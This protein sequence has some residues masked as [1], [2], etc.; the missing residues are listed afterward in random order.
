MIGLFITLSIITTTCFI[1]AFVT[2]TIDLI[3]EI[4]NFFRN[5]QGKG[6][7]Q[8]KYNNVNLWLIAT[9]CLLICTMGLLF[10]Y[11]L[12]GYCNLPNKF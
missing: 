7:I 12:Y 1:I 6:K 8:P 10:M 3:I 4:I 9:W 11:L 2:M 5:I